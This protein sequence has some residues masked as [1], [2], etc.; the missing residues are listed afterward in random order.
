MATL[1]FVLDKWFADLTNALALNDS[2]KNAES[3]EAR[4]KRIISEKGILPLMNIFDIATADLTRADSVKLRPK[5]RKHFERKGETANQ[6][7]N[8]MPRRLLATMLQKKIQ[9]DGNKSP[10]SPTDLGKIQLALRLKDA[11]IG[12]LREMAYD[13]FSGESLK[14]VVSYIPA[15]SAYDYVYASAVRDIYDAISKIFKEF[16]KLVDGETHL[17]IVQLAVLESC[18]TLRPFTC[19]R[20]LCACIVDVSGDIRNRL[21]KHA[22][23][24]SGSFLQEIYRVEQHKSLAKIFATTIGSHAI[25]PRTVRRITDFVHNYKRSSVN[26]GTPQTRAKQVTPVKLARKTKIVETGKSDN[27]GS[28]VYLVINKELKKPKGFGEGKNTVRSAAKKRKLKHIGEPEG[29]K[30]DEPV[31]Q[32]QPDQAKLCET[33]IVEQTSLSEIQTH[34]DV[35]VAG[36]VMVQAASPQQHHQ[37][38]EFHTDFKGGQREPLE[39]WNPQKM[40]CHQPPQ[41]MDTE[42]TGGANNEELDGGESVGTSSYVTSS[43]SDS[44][45][46]SEESSASL[47]E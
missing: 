7:K 2:L 8:A 15:V 39:S 18:S 45:S 25:D 42:M 11:N 6:L 41:M 4:T 21:G 43:E 9:T 29:Q 1:W 31:A 36:K 22:A 20:T 30:P 34:G 28:A 44:D 46:D 24:T 17:R 19:D 14:S 10:L 5:A 38:E 16:P 23:S 27:V 47:Y 13:G 32:A 37:H 12:L 40:E 3:E 35:N 26:R 33:E